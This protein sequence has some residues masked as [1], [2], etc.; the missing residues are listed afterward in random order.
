M[1]DK[2]VTLFPARKSPAPNLFDRAR[3]GRRTALADRT[4]TIIQAAGDDGKIVE[5]RFLVMPRIADLIAR[6][7]ANARVIGMR[8]EKLDK[9]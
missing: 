5:H 6:L 2:I 4:V 9:D 7:G 3:T 8:V 1:T